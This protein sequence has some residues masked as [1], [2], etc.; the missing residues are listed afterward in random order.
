MK[1][2]AINSLKVEFKP[3]NKNNKKTSLNFDDLLN[4][5]ST[6]EVPTNSSSSI[7][8]ENQ[9][10]QQD[11]ANPT[12][13][14]DNSDDVE[15]VKD[16]I[17]KLEKLIEKLTN[18]TEFSKDLKE[19]QENIEPFLNQIIAFVNS[20]NQYIINSKVES[21]DKVNTE[22]SLVNIVNIRDIN[23]KLLG[24]LMNTEKV[25]NYNQTENLKEI[26]ELLDGIL[27]SDKVDKNQFITV[28]QKIV[29][30]NYKNEPVKMSIPNDEIIEKPEMQNDD[31]SVSEIKKENLR[32]G[33]DNLT[34]TISDKAAVN[35][36]VEKR[37]ND[38]K[39]VQNEA[40]VDED[41]SFNNANVEL[42]SIKT[43]TNEVN[44]NDLRAEI[45]RIITPQKTNEIIQIAVERFRSLRLPEITE[46]RVKLNPEDLGEITVKVVLEKGE[47]KG[48]ILV[49][50]REVA[51]ALQS[52]IENLKQEL[53]NNNVTVTNVT[54]NLNNDN[55]NERNGHGFKQQ[56]GQ[57]KNYSEQQF[58]FDKLVDDQ[59]GL[60][61]IA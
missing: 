50:K 27:G 47:V 19:P 9:H 34:K 12:E 61:I 40:Q 2:D 35:I 33:D 53:R 56:N 42:K 58:E 22:N 7:K 16:V 4:K 26:N 57:N 39:A 30:N 41:I 24:L 13:F 59:D 49:D 23:I 5:V 44:K 54:I 55:L 48:N 25:E 38:D 6:K 43:N 45:E 3:G 37:S 52:Q 14:E 18:D 17:A 11:I 20:L 31:S 60:N 51:A 21:T 10:N 28:L 36:A 46:L 1:V 15:L 8:V 32:S 29:E